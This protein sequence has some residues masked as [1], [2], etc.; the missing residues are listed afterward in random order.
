MNRFTGEISFKWFTAIVVNIDDP[1][2]L[3]Y[4]QIRVD[5]LH[6]TFDDEQ[7]PWAAP[8]VPITSASLDGV[9]ISPTGIKVNSFVFGF[10][11]DG[12]DANVPLIVGTIPAIKEGDVNKHDVSLLARGVN[13]LLKQPIGPEPGSS[14]ASA[15]PFNKVVETESGHVIEL[16]DTPGAERIHIYHKSGTYIEINQDGRSVTK[17][18]G[19][20]YKIVARNETIHIEGRANVVVKG[21][22]SITALDSAQVTVHNN[23]DLTAGGNLNLTAQGDITLSSNRNINMSA[24]QNL[25]IDA[26]NL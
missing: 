14:Y 21:P 26:R 9:G 7:L 12:E 24:R 16:D 8:I 11:A 20:D 4:C 13:K 15:Y 25:N 23:V 10:F 18:A 22:V 5:G 1:D 3:G 2:K 6:D 17:V 19:D